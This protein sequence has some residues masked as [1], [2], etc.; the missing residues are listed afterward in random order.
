MAENTERAKFSLSD[1]RI[2]I[3]GSESFVAGQLEKLEP[4]LKTMFEHRPLSSPLTSAATGSTS[5]TSAAVD[6]GNGLGDFLNVFALADGKVQILK[7]LPGSGKA[8]KAFNAALLVAFANELK[9][10][11]STLVEEVRAICI[12]HAC[13]DQ[14]NFSKTFRGTNGKESFTVSGN[15]GA[16]SIALTHPGK[17]KAKLIAD[18]L[19]K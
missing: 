13:Y 14:A 15:G 6:A 3:E 18:S 7:T 19:N 4:L 8:N 9:G 11:K 5:T 12:S 10:T 17:T 1:G 2:E 16:Q